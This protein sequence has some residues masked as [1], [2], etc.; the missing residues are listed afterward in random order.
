MYEVALNRDT[1]TIVQV[2]IEDAEKVEESIKTWLGKDGSKRKE[3]I[4]EE[5]YKYVD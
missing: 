1:R 5:L 4:A 3:I 2:T